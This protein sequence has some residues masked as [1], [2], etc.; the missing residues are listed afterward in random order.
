MENPNFFVYKEDSSRFI[1]IFMDYWLHF[2]ILLW[3]SPF[4]LFHFKKIGPFSPL[5]FIKHNHHLHHHLMDYCSLIRPLPLCQFLQPYWVWNFDCS[6][7]VSHPFWKKKA[8]N[9][10]HL[11]HQSLSAPACTLCYKMV[12][13]LCITTITNLNHKISINQVQTLSLNHLTQKKKKNQIFG[14]IY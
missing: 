14:H 12:C 5:I 10:S 7:I 4:H 8:S 2:I 3:N 6:L 1:R 9:F 11:P 13:Y